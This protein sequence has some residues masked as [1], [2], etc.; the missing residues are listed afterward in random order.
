MVAPG[1]AVLGPFFDTAMS[2]N[3]LT[4]TEPEPLLLPL[5]GS[6]V[7]EPMFAPI[8]SIPAWFGAVVLTVIVEVPTGRLAAVHWAVD[9]V[10]VQANPGQDAPVIV[11][12]PEMPML[13][14]TLAAASGPPLPTL[15]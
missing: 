14:T 9:D 8:V 3:A 6:K 15:M 13:T 1:E 11:P 2:A 7:D 4:I 10:N 12:P 5:F